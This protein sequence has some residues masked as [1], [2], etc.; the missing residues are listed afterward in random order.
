MRIE[1]YLSDSAA[2]FPEKLA[3]VEGERRLTYRELDEQANR[4]ALLLCQVGVKPGDRVAVFADN[5]ADAVVALFAAMRCGGVFAPLNPSTKADKLAML[6]SAWQASI[7]LAQAKL[8]PTV[9]KALPQS[10]S[11]RKCIIL[12][13]PAPS[14]AEPGFIHAPSAAPAEGRL[15]EGGI[16][17]DLAMLLHT[18]GSTGAPKGVMLSHANLSTA[19]DSVVQY[20]SLTSADVLLNVLPLSHGYGLSQLLTGIRV[21]ATVI[22][23]KSFA[24][25]RAVLNNM[26]RYQVTG[27]ALAPTIAAMLLQTSLPPGGLPS[28]RFLTN[29]AAAMPVPHLLRLQ[30]MFP[31]AQIFSMYGQTEC[32]RGTFLDPA[33]LKTR[34]DSVGR[35][36]PNTEAYVIDDQG[37][38]AAPG[39]VGELVI[40]GGHVMCGYWQ[41]P[42]ATEKSLKPGDHPWEH[43]LYTGDLFRVDEE[44]YLYFVS[45]QDD[46]IKTR[47][48]KVSPREIEDVLYELPQ[49]Q[50]AAAIG[51]SDP[52]LGMAIKVAIVLSEPGSLT[53]KD[54]LRHVA[55]RLED[56]MV[57]R[58]I[59][60]CTQLPKTET[61]KIRRAE[62]RRQSAEMASA[63]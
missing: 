30:E 2:R 62:V 54:I 41:N 53:E 13:G 26:A 47:G 44:G 43:C 5:S 10:P 40:R 21:G 52:V 61:G 46:I 12:D 29:A 48:E 39:V 60:F 37:Q 16:D 31:H 3:I 36:I 17:I 49:I 14:A 24:F 63:S 20:L 35:A 11:I 38:R 25:P 18:S 8:L 23:E 27:F 51:V 59:E 33:Q 4:L 56:Y 9:R 6:L 32:I 57:P 7:I 34:P 19:F 42:L 22:I 1:S 50:E 28:L 58:F 55:S 15:P 45:R